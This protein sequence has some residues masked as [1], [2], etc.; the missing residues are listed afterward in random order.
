M[1]RVNVREV[2]RERTHSIRK[3]LSQLPVSVYVK[4]TKLSL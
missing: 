1:R 4:V 3:L 2:K